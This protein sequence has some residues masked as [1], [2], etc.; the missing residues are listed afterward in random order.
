MKG[1]RCCGRDGSA[2]KLDTALP[3]ADATPGRPERE[4]STP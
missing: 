4:G 3:M 2:L 1:K